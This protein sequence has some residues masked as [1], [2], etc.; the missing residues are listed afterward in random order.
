MSNNKLT[1]NIRVF[2]SFF[3]FSNLTTTGNNNHKHDNRPPVYKVFRVFGVTSVAH[4]VVIV[5]SQLWRL[6]WRKHSER[7]EVCTRQG[8]GLWQHECKYSLPP[9]KWRTETFTKYI[10]RANGVF[11]FITNFCRDANLFVLNHCGQRTYI[12]AALSVVLRPYA[13]KLNVQIQTT[14]CTD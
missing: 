3:S 1:T 9:S 13:L 8:T 12:W 10:D 14:H 4:D 2:F 6:Q 7:L 11:C 5:L